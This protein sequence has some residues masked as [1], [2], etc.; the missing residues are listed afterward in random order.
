MKMRR[1]GEPDGLE[2]WTGRILRKEMSPE[3][4]AKSFFFSD[5]FSNKGLAT[6]S[7]VLFS[8]GFTQASDGPA[9]S[10]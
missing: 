6:N 5:E 10:L 4:V 2:D 1:E 7:L 3:D 9:A 8:S